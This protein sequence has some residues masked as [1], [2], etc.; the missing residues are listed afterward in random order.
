MLRSIINYIFSIKMNRVKAHELRNKSEAECT[1]ELTKHRVRT[2]LIAFVNKGPIW[3]WILSLFIVKNRRNLLPSVSV[4]SQPL[5]KLNSPKFVL[6]V[7]TSPKSSPSWTKRD[8]LKLEMPSRKRST[9]LMILEPRVL[10]LSVER[11]P[12]SKE[13]SKPSER[14]KRAPTTRWES[15]PSPHER[16]FENVKYRRRKC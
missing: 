2:Y 16:G 5:P 15:T 14:S 4:K 13:P 7:K 6:S 9:H 10:E 3:N 1:E 11:C 12:N 8:V